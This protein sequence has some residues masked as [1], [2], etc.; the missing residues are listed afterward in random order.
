[1]NI[2]VIGGTLFIGR[3]L[4][5]RLLE[6]GH[7]VT[8]LHRKESHEF[9]DAVRNLQADRK[10]IAA[11]TRIFREEPFEA[12]FDNVYDWEYGTT[13]QQVAE[14]AQAAG[15][16]L[17]RYIFMSSVAAYGSGLSHSEDDELAPPDD[18]NPYVLSLI[19]I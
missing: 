16:P 5:K 9:G 11:M 7:S 14:P 8:V 15:L 18:P 1:M 6:E 17:K 4:V 13:A 2:L 3:H 19:H 12:V 10:D